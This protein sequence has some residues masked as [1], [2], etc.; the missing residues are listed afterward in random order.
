MWDY[1][2][3]PQGL[4]DCYIRTPSNQEALMKG[5]IGGILIIAIG[6]WLRDSV[7][8][9]QFSVR[10]IIFDAL[11]LYFVIRGAISLYRAKQQETATRQ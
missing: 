8:L 11:G 10:A 4:K 6:L 2:P 7:F 9:G 1:F 5:I 3:C